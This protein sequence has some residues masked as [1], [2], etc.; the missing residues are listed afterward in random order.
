MPVERIIAAAT[1]IVDEDG[2]EALTMRTLAQRL[3]SGT[4]TLY[5][6]FRSRAQLIAHVIDTVLGEADIDAAAAREMPWRQVVESGARTLFEVFRAHPQV[7]RLLAERIPMGPNA[8]R[9]REFMIAALLAAGFGPELAAQAY[10]TVARFVL[11]FAIQ[12]GEH[13]TDDDAELPETWRA[14][15]PQSYPATVA[16]AD[17]LPV[18]LEREFSLG[19]ELILNGLTQLLDDADLPTAVPTS[20]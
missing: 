6:H 9:Q 4:A 7:A 1:E 8:M 16:V 2:A 11:G 5:R 14:Q 12:L 19:L 10:A 13:P 15:D 17:H 3:D 20:T 18:G